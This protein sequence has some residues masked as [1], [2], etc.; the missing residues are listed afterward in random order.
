MMESSLLP[1]GWK[2]LPLLKEVVEEGQTLVQRMVAG[3]EEQKTLRSRS[4]E[5]Q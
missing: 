1:V 2:V 3:E 5:Q 4:A